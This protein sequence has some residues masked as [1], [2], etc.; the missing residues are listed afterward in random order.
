MPHRPARKENMK[1]LKNNKGVTGIDIVVSVTLIVITLGIVMAVY[2]SYANKT[3]E[4]KRNST[5]TNLAMTV[6]E[7]IETIKDI[8]HTD[9]SNITKDGISITGGY[10]L[11]G[12]VSQGYTIN[13]RKVNSDSTIL[14]N[15]AFQIDVTVSYKVGNE[16]KKVTLSTIKKYNEVGEAEA[17]DMTSSSIAG[18]VPVK[19][20]SA[21]GGY[22]KTDENDSEWYSISSKI[23]PIVIKPKEGEDFD[24]NG[25]IQ[26]E[27]CS[28]IYVWVPYY[29]QD[30]SNNY[31][32]CD[33][34]GK[35]IKYEK[36]INN[37]SKYTT[38]S[39]DSLS[40]V[41]GGDWQKIN[42]DKKPINASNEEITSDDND[43][44][45]VKNNIFTWQ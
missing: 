24:R 32:F 27:N 35:I 36:D 6:I 25:V 7:Y 42:A 45:I 8:N 19:Y 11:T 20:D 40:T 17:P 9:I 23:Y 14:Q 3:K 22:V 15:I 28:D 16:D 2:T 1:N 34:S 18:C 31:R 38:V 10:G 41:K 26:L 13:A 30:S 21:K 29:G 12:G 5:A 43:Y 33:E 37:I 39:T 4:V 44:N